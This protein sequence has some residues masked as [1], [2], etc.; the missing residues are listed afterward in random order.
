MSYEARCIRQYQSHTRKRDNG[1]LMIRIESGLWDIF[2][3]IGFGN[4]SRFRI[5]KLRG[6]SQPKLICVAGQHI[7]NELRQQLIKECV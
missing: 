7:P 2:Y 5:F 3:G 1:D 4:S 6:D